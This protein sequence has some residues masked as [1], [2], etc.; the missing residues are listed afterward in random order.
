MLLARIGAR[1]EI[2]ARLRGRL[3]ELLALSDVDLLE[4]VG[5]A[6]GVEAAEQPRA[7]AHAAQAICVH[8]ARYPPSLSDGGAPRLLFVGGGVERF[9]ALSG[10]STVALCGSARST[11][12]GIEMARG[13]ASEL[14]GRGVTIV[15]G[16]DDA[17]GA[18]AQSAASTL[19]WGGIAVLAGGLDV[20]T[21]AT[22]RTL[23]EEVRRSG[24]VV[25]ELP[26]SCEGRVWG[27]IAAARTIARLA[28]VTVVVEADDTPV[29]M[30]AAQV[31]RALGKTLAAMPGRVT[32]RASRGAHTLLREGARLVRD[33]DD[34]ISLIG[35]PHDPAQGIG[36]PLEDALD[37]TLRLTLERVGAGCDAPDKLARDGLE[38]ADALL[39]LSRLE[40]LGLLARGDGGRY[41]RCAHTT[42]R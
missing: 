32:S 25:A 3:L 10:G 5:C 35:L 30:S 34:V 42:A 37:A 17:V 24:C 14:A 29:E 39:A 36:A 31:A 41:V 18:A 6:G 8:D 11:D 12:Y 2:R 9:A 38:V 33:V 19:G 26:A 13:L 1:L 23:A 22:R 40:V 16:I 27:R 4:A 21:L 15:S 20:G 28:A 7:P